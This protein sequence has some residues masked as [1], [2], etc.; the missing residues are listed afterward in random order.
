ME[1]STNEAWE[2][3]YE[4]RGIVAAGTGMEALREKARLVLLKFSEVES[5]VTTIRP[6]AVL[7]KSGAE[8]AVSVRAYIVKSASVTE[9][10][11]DADTLGLREGFFIPPAWADDPYMVISLQD[12][13]IEKFTLIVQRKR[14]GRVMPPVNVKTT[15]GRAAANLSALQHVAKLWGGGDV[16]AYTVVG[17]IAGDVNVLEWP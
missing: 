13:S 4:G 17:V 12:E 9:A 8:T 6:Y 15:E 1:N 14:D 7:L 2:I 11:R 16:G 5:S 10:Q 3:C